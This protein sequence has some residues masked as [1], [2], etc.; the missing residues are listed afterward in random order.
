M[1]EYR[2]EKSSFDESTSAGFA[3]TDLAADCWAPNKPTQIS[4]K[5]DSGA[6]ED[7]LTQIALVAALAAGAAGVI[8]MV[9]S[10]GDGGPATAPGSKKAPVTEP[11]E[12]AKT[13][14]AEADTKIIPQPEPKTAIIEPKTAVI[15]PKTAVI[16]PKTAVIES[17][18]AVTEPKTA[19]IEVKPKVTTEPPSPRLVPGAVLEIGA[20]KFTVHTYDFSR[21]LLVLAT[22]DQNYSAQRL[23][24]DKV[25]ADYESFSLNGKDYLRHKTKGDTLYEVT[26]SF[27]DES[28]DIASTDLVGMRISKI[29]RQAGVKPTELSSRKAIE[30]VNR[31]FLSAVT[32]LPAPA[33]VN[34]EESGEFNGRKVTV[35]T[36]GL[37]DREVEIDGKKFNFEG[38][39]KGWFFSPNFA[40]P[41]HEKF[42]IG[43]TKVGVTTLNAQDFAKVHAELVPELYRACQKGGELYGKVAQFKT[44][45]PMYPLVPDWELLLPY[46]DSKEPGNIL[47]PGPTG[48]D[49]KGFTVFCTDAEAAMEVQKHIDNFLSK[50]GLSLTGNINTQNMC[51]RTRSS[52][53]ARRATITRDL[54]ETGYRGSEI[55]AILPKEI[56]D[57]ARR[58]AEQQVK[59][60]SGNWQKYSSVQDLYENFESGLLKKQVLNQ[61]AADCKF[62]PSCKL[63]YSS[64]NKLMFVDV[65]NTKRTFNGDTYISEAGAKGLVT[66]DSKTGE[67]SKGLTGRPAFFGLISKLEKSLDVALEPAHLEAA[68]IKAER[69]AP[70]SDTKTDTTSVPSEAPT[71]AKDAGVPATFLDAKERAAAEKVLRD[72]N[73]KLTQMNIFKRLVDAEINDTVDP[74]EKETLKALKKKLAGLDATSGPKTVDAI[75]PPEEV[76]VSSNR[77][78]GSEPVGAGPSPTGEGAGG[79]PGADKSATA[80]RPGPK[81]SLTGDGKEALDPN[82]TKPGE[83]AG[84]SKPRLKAEVKDK[85]SSGIQKNLGRATGAFILLDAA[86]QYALGEK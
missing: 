26:K 36:D 61:I 52:E 78:A 18:T 11:K 19:V 83:T 79:L 16:E 34:S 68:R 40:G 28:K 27:P 60:K 57:A 67:I 43:N 86:L 76:P 17:K 71:M 14:P 5:R 13:L 23:S 48:Q 41:D 15:E 53:G 3:W 74:A 29:A 45:D 21:D 82:G 4:S 51:D 73:P 24:A 84:E 6:V 39:N 32:R 70:S 38:F 42:A 9:R 47:K 44:L 49:T 46:N 66:Y 81:P 75:L 33:F 65:A 10:R 69:T 12:N 80:L 62:D 8:Y 77:V 55:G 22:G 25:A 31:I 30:G 58:Y 56:S 37:K 54:F 72:L 63:R 64:E 20:S 85:P 2:D 35:R 50:K 59:N 7:D 1:R